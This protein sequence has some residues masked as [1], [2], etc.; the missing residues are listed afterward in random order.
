[1]KPGLY[2]RLYVWL[3]AHRPAVLGLMLVLGA[4]SVIISSRM[5]LE[6]DLLA[7]LPQHDK[8]VD[9]YRYALRKFHQIDRV[10]LDVGINAD[11][12]DRLARAADEV[13][14]LLSTNSVYERITYRIEVG[15][16]KQSIDFL[17]GALPNLFTAADA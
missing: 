11:D 17:T 10:Y 9:E 6:E 3:V 8:L 13:Y 2:T 14:A 4:G 16:Q 1:M 12:P 15:G 5:D 7:T